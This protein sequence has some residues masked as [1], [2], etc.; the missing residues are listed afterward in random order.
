[1]NVWLRESGIPAL[2]IELT[3]P[4]SPEIDRNIRALR[5]V[6]QQLAEAP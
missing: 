2:L 3:S 6:L 4:S 5:A 1:M